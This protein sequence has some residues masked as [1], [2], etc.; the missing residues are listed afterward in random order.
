MAQKVDTCSQKKGC[1]TVHVDAMLL[2]CAVL[3]QQWVN[4]LISKYWIYESVSQF[5]LADIGHDHPSFTLSYYV[6][7]ATCYV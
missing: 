1:T 5:D 4:G 6:L 2:L 7:H 3:Y